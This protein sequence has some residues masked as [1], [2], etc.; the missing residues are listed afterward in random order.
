M[1]F[2]KEISII[3][4]LIGMCGCILLYYRNYEIEGLFYA[5]VIQMQLIEYLL[6]LNNKCNWINKII[7]KIGILLNHLQPIILYFLIIYLNSNLDKNTKIFIHIII[8]IYIITTITYLIYNYKLLYSCTIGIENKKELLWKIQYG[9][10]F[11]YY[12]IFVFALFFMILFGFKK[13]NYLNAYII[14]ASIIISYIVY[15]KSKAVGT[16]WCLFAAYIPLLLNI[17]YT[18]K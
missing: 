1:C 13:H 6:W 15:D 8:I 11:E 12:H 18:I 17:I 16:I 9:H 2:N 14:L 3:S 7:T 4:Y 10:L 5:F